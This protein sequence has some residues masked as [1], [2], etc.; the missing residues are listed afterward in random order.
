MKCVNDDEWQLLTIKFTKHNSQ[1]QYMCLQ[2]I[3]S[4]NLL[5]VLTQ[6]QMFIISAYNRV[7][8]RAGIV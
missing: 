2:I 5:H 4:V 3:L 6:K 1:R 8:L 7:F